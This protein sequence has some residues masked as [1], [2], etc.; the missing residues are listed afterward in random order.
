MLS[1]SDGTRFSTLGVEVINV[2]LSFDCAEGATE[3]E[4]KSAIQRAI[5]RHAD[6]WLDDSHEVYAT[7]LQLNVKLR[8]IEAECEVEVTAYGD[9][10]AIIAE[11][12][13]IL[14]HDYEGIN[15]YAAGIKFFYDLEI[16]D[17]SWYLEANGLQRYEEG[18]TLVIDLG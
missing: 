5:D 12:G 2:K 17:L 9:V 10:D 14:G 3:E 18:G 1:R 16:K 7:D 15:E 6:I 13:S 11:D 4:V 8:G